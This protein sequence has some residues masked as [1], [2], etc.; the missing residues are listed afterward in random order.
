MV[1]Q[2]IYDLVSEIPNGKVLSYGTIAKIMGM[3][4][5]RKVGFALHA[6]RNTN[7]IPCHRVV[8]SDGRLASGYAFGGPNVQKELLAAEGVPFISDKQVDIEKA[9]WEVPD[10]LS[11]RIAQKFQKYKKGRK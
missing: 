4:D 3:K 11:E 7:K 10:D 1:F 5:V 9:L 6:N 2:I 8:T